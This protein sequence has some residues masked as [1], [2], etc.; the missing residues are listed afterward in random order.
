MDIPTLHFN[1]IVSILRRDAEHKPALCY[2][3]KTHEAFYKRMA[4]DLNK[5]WVVWTLI[6]NIYHVVIFNIYYGY[7]VGRG[8]I[9]M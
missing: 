6:F 5:S 3:I 2:I 7:K 9:L 4:F 8:M 1:I